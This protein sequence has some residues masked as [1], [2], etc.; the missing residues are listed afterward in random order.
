MLTFKFLKKAEGIIRKIN[1]DL[2]LW[3]TLVIK[4]TAIVG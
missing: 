3:R 4:Y 1:R 2:R